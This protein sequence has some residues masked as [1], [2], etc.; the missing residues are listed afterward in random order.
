MLHSFF[1][2]GLALL[3]LAPGPTNMV[4]A[5]AAASR[6]IGRSAPLPLVVLAAYLATILPLTLLAVPVLRAYP[7]LGD[8]IAGLAALWVV[9]L[10]VR[11]WKAPVSGRD[12]AP[13]STSDLFVTTLLNPKG[14]VIALA[15]LPGQPQ[16][17][18]LLAVAVVIL[19]VSMVWLLFGATAVRAVSSRY[20]VAFA[21]SA[22]FS[23][24]L[25]AVTLASRAAGLV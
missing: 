9:L 17:Q 4:L 24:M 21:R 10:A 19:L 23:L 1:I 14:I 8:A 18:G 11:L 3:L 20:P 13:V 5:L 16:P 7:A 15:M 12:M 6:G 2:P 22:S 25:F